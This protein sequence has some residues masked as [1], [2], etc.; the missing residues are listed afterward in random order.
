[1]KLVNFVW[2]L[3]FSALV[4]GTSGYAPETEVAETAP[5]KV[6]AVDNGPA[7]YSTA[8]EEGITIYLRHPHTG[9]LLD[10]ATT[11]YDGVTFYPE[12]DTEFYVTTVGAT[13]A[14][15]GGTYGFYQEHSGEGV[16]SFMI[17]Q[18][19]DTYELCRL[20]DDS[21]CSY[22]DPAFLILYK[23]REETEPSPVCGGS[24]IY[25]GESR[26]L[27]NYYE[28]D[29]REVT[30][31]EYVNTL[32]IYL[33]SDG[34]YLGG[35]GGYASTNNPVYYTAADGTVFKV[36][37]CQVHYDSDP[38]N[39]WIELLVEEPRTVPVETEEAVPVEEA[40]TE[41]TG[42]TVIFGVGV[43]N[44]PDTEDYVT[45]SNIDG[46]V[47]MYIVTPVSSGVYRG[48]LIQTQ[49]VYSYD[50]ADF[51]VYAGEIVD[52]VGFESYEN[53]RAAS[54]WTFSAPPYKNFGDDPD[55]LCQ[56]NYLNTNEK[57]VLADGRYSCATSL[58]TPYQD[59]IT[60]E[61]TATEE[62][63]VIG[64]SNFQCPYSKRGH[65]TMK[66]LQEEFGDRLEYK[67]KHFPLAF[68]QYAQKAAEA[69]E[70]AR[71]QA[72]FDEY[73]DTLFENS[74]QLGIDSLKRYAAELGLDTVT[75][76]QCLDNGEKAWIIERH[77]E[78]GEALGVSG[79][80]T[81]FINGVMVVGAQP[82]DEF[83][84]LINEAIST[85]S[86]TTT[87][88]VE[89]IVK[90]NVLQVYV[91]ENE[92]WRGHGVPVRDASVTMYGYADGSV[93]DSENTEQRDYVKFELPEDG[94]EVYFVAS[95]D[96]IR[97]THYTTWYAYDES[98]DEIC[99]LEGSEM[100]CPPYVGTT[101]Y[102]EIVEE[103]TTEE[104][105]TEP[106]PVE[107]EEVPEE[108]AT[109]EDLPW[110]GEQK[111]VA[112]QLQKGWNMF[113]LPFVYGNLVSSTCDRET[114]FTYDP[115]EREY[116][117]EYISNKQYYG[118]AGYWMKAS[119][120]CILEIA[121]DNLQSFYFGE[122]IVDMSQR[123]MYKGWNQIGAPYDGVFMEDILG[124]CEIKSGPWW[125]NPNTRSWE[126]SQ[127]LYEGK[128]Y[129]VKIV[130]D[131]ELGEEMPPLPGE[132]P[133]VLP[134]D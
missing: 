49:R 39:R 36:Y 21:E 121:A 108:E 106:E 133:P 17:S 83:R 98:Y 93:L 114:I 79:T 123:F 132:V 8:S 47:N 94:T 23:L 24:I 70:C 68:H 7:G 66:Q 62:G 13:G 97:Y 4:F 16:P 81:F 29:L 38:N 48:T 76:N 74:P 25:E 41:V 37:L 12:L 85:S 95:K 99:G 125:Y 89:E 2:I 105:E 46:W 14:A 18:Y 119:Q 45:T 71:D 120:T 42:Y 88:P 64:Y 84:A 11:T 113:S 134:V 91:W 69:S 75:F 90:N 9:E 33:K 44:Y 59:E 20:G 101:L 112:V 118:F 128:G 102:P 63:Y 107:E 6:I 122:D 86:E 103:D 50:G 35:I 40:T 78:E 28:F 19:G 80:P 15:V 72:M 57:M 61:T 82:I 60:T 31:S 3:V 96:G 56:I 27:L 87:E 53:A 34:S 111:I 104:E 124:T 54:E 127:R 130:E 116:L 115:E 26:D 109:E 100:I 43:N 52:F 58:S 65:D 73:A 32:M 10:Q 131:C 22:S 1:M 5:L 129:F 30:S 67:I 126:K 77:V 55:E 51:Y 117:K 110:I 92:R